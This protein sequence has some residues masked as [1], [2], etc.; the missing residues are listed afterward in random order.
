VNS[1]TGKPFAFCSCVNEGDKCDERSESHF[2]I[3]QTSS[4]ENLPKIFQRSSSNIL[5]SESENM[6]SPCVCNGIL[7]F[8]VPLWRIA[9]HHLEFGLPRS[10]IRL[11]VSRAKPSTIWNSP[12]SIET[13]QR[14][15]H[16]RCHTPV[17]HTETQIHNLCVYSALC[18][19]GIKFGLD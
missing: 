4:K 15:R 19:S 3:F 13:P 9:V 1:L 5:I 2:L 16:D 17:H 11:P 7:T 18:N 12:S 8:L 14:V 6:L 10:G